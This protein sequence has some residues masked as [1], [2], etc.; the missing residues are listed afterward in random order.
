MNKIHVSGSLVILGCGAVSRCLQQLLLRHL[1]M[2]FSKLFIIDKQNNSSHIPLI[3]QKGA[4]FIEKEITLESMDQILSKYLKPHDILIDLATGIPTIDLIDWCQKNNVLFLNTAV[5]WP[6]KIERK[7]QF[8]PQNTLYAQH[9]ALAEKSKSWPINGPTAIVEH[10]ANPGL[11]SHWTKVALEEISLYLLEKGTDKQKDLEKCL[12]NNNFSELAYLTGTKVIHISERDT[13]IT[14]Q[15]KRVNE[16]VNTWSVVGLYEEALLPAEL[17]WG[18]HEKFIPQLIHEHDFGPRN[19]A[20]INRFGMNTSLYSWV[21]SGDII[22]MLISHGESYTISDHLT[23]RRDNEVVYRPSVYF[24]YLVSDGTLASLHELRMHDYRLQE[25]QRIMNDDII[26]G[27]DQMG[28]L[29]LGDH[30]NGWW[31]GSTLST[32]ETRK[33][34]GPGHNGTTLQVAASILGALSWMVHNTHEGLCMPDD[35]PYK[36]ILAI[37]NPYLGEISSVQTDWRP[38]QKGPVTFQIS[39]FLVTL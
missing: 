4:H 17:G 34:V 37:A 25:D 2:D 32:H 20:F 23:L 1:E 30:Y 36:E 6:S 16:F 9:V 14:H 28:V 38:P 18:T 29:L 35:L 12:A 21:P 24:V 5:E 15:P 7:E 11:V 26:D 10:G 3:L 31:T 8:D 13:Q 33:L 22:G 19:Q 27:Y 39:D